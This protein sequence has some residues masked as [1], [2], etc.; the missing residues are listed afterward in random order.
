MYD[1]DTVIEDLIALIEITEHFMDTAHF[2]GGSR[3]RLER[4]IKELKEKYGED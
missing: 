1:A 4:Q 2:Y 3:K